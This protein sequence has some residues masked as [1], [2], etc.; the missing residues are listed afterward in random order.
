MTW[1]HERKKPYACKLCDYSSVS[2][3]TLTNHQRMVS[4][5]YLLTSKYR[6]FFVK[7]AWVY[8]R[9]RS[10]EI[11]NQAKQ[12]VVTKQVLAL[13]PFFNFSVMLQSTGLFLRSNFMRLNK[14]S[15]PSF[16]CMLE[17]DLLH[18]IFKW[19][20]LL[21]PSSFFSSW[22]ISLVIH[23]CNGYL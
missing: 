6:E 7:T 18:I 4:N 11:W 8:V 12:L 22:N 16:H 1:V 21:C 14:S 5:Y 13:F 20:Y 2:K 17:Y 19:P 15:E 9:W 23:Y 3:S 10:K